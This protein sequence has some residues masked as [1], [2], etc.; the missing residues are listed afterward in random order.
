MSAWQPIA[1]APKDGS[2]ITLLIPYAGS[3]L[4]EARCT[5][6]GHWEPL[7]PDDKLYPHLTPQWALEAGGCWRF[8]GDDGPFDIQP[9]HWKPYAGD[10]Q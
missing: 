10:E 3:G 1:T 2:L 6:K 9:T 8:E 7:S 5:D 4:S